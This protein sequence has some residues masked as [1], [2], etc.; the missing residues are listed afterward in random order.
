MAITITIDEGFYVDPKTNQTFF[1]KIVKDKPLIPPWV[2]TPPHQWKK[3]K[4]KT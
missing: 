3:L 1:L 4:K 2:K